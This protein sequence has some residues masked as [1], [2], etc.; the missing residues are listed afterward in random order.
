MLVSGVVALKVLLVYQEPRQ[1]MSQAKK[2][3]KT[4]NKKTN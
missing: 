4:T 1:Y 2:F 3:Q